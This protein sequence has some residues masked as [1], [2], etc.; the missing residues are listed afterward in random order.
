[1]D[2]P[3]QHYSLQQRRTI[4]FCFMVFDAL[5]ELEDLTWMDEHVAF[6]KRL[7][8]RYGRAT[9]ERCRLFHA[10]CGSGVSPDVAVT[11]FDFAGEDSILLKMCELG[12]AY[13]DA[14]YFEIVRRSCRIPEED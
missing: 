13:L 6:I 14:D 8:Q 3:D 10:A 1:M 5:T 7:R 11:C 2:N 9:A 12:S 4:R